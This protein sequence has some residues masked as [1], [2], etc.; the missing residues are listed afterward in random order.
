MLIAAFRAT[1]EEVVEADVILHVRD[2]AHDE[3][4]AQSVAA[5]QGQLPRCEE[6]PPVLRG[7]TGPK[8]T[9]FTVQV[10]AAG[11]FQRGAVRSEGPEKFRTSAMLRA[12]ASRGVSGASPHRHSIILS[13]EAWS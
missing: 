7:I 6:S 11:T 13:T 1:L 2:A 10:G 3:S 5:G 9:P 8:R 12:A 4:E